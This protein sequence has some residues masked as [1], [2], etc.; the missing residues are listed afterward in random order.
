VSLPPGTRLGPYEVLSPLGAGGMGEVYRARDS[1]LR[2]DVAIKILPA[3]FASD[4]ERRARFAREAQLLAA[5]N[6]PHIAAIYGVEES[7]AV[8]ALVLELVEGP[9]LEDRIAGRAVPVPEA[10]AIAEQIAEALDAAHEKGIVH[11]DLKPANVKLTRDGQVKVLDFGLAKA[12]DSP[13]GTGAVSDASQSPTLTA[14]A[15][16]LGVIVGT[17]AFMSPEQAKG[18]P[19]DKRT[20]IW[21]FGCV[22]YEMLQGRRAFTGEDVTDFVVAVMTREPDWAALP[23]AVP[24]RIVELLKR[25]LKK[26]ARERLRDIGD[27]RTEIREALANASAGHPTRADERTPPPRRHAR[28]AAWT[29]LGALLGAGALGAGLFSLGLIPIRAVAP[30]APVV[31]FSISVPEGAAS[32]RISPDGRLLAFVELNGPRR[33]WVRPLDSLEA[34]PLSGTEDA[35]EPFWSADS[36]FLGFF[37]KGKLKKVD[38]AGGPPMDLC[39]AP[40][41]LGGAWSRDNVIVFAPRSAGRLQKLSAAGGSPVPV[42]SLDKEA[43]RHGSAVFLP[44]GQHLVFWAN[45]TTGGHAYLGSLA[46]PEVTLLPAVTSPPA[47]APGALLFRRDGTLLRQPFD[48]ARLQPTGDPTPVAEKVSDFSVSLTGVL[49]YTPAP[50]P[51]QRRLVWVDRKGAVTPLPLAAGDYSDPTL[52]PDGRQIALVRREPS[53]AHV[54]VYDILQGTLQKRTFEGENWFPIW[55]PDG[56]QLTF[57]RGPDYIGPLLQMPA[58]GSGKAAPLVTDEQRGGEKV[59]T[60]WS[61]DGRLLAFQNNQDVIV[62]EADGTLHPALA[63]PAFEREGRFAPGGRWLAYRSSETGR[64]EVYVQSYPP[65]GGKWQISTDGGAQPMW[66]AGGRELFYK[67]GNRMMSVATEAGETF[68]AGTPRAL[69]EMPQPAERDLGDPARYGVTPDGQR[70]LV[71]TTGQGESAAGSTQIVVVQSWVEGLAR[72]APAK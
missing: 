51:L 68:K 48:L 33:I 18:K 23:A 10:L 35:Q 24:P 7:E 63:T 20:D 1:K 37:A 44:D 57:T 42:T 72:L 29:V 46:S 11:R 56:R 2:R 47:Y 69:F 60:S 62:R 12:L 17:A 16:R 58:D 14:V 36:R 8:T 71:V 66:A 54:Y 67:S 32:P 64:D 50:P 53:G 65:G 27:A 45:T 19:V 31:R 25:C 5:L 28:A 30:G 15:S 49:V 38:V 41:G 6:H 55:T 4:P 21:A 34:R 40:E 26:D 22:L 59:A 70:F 61:A 3:A 39:D 52:S 13:G 9:T 43:Q